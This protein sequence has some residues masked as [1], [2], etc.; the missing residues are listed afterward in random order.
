MKVF[1]DNNLPPL[2]AASIAALCRHEQDVTE[3]THLR[4]MFPHATPDAEWLK[5]LSDR[6]GSWIV[7]SIDKFKKD[8]RAEREAI[9][10]AGHTVY[11]LDPQWSG[12]PFWPK[13]ARLTLWWPLILAHARLT[14]GGVHRVPWRHTA[15]SKF[16]AT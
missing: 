7:V 12:Q 11:V 5:A 13:A 10:R 9:R 6:G 1:F 8:R 3:V 14:S 2:L 15:Q 16:Q 4:E